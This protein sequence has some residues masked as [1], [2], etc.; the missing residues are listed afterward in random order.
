MFRAFRALVIELGQSRKIVP[1]K[2]N[3]A[4]P[5]KKGS[6]AGST[7]SCQ[8]QWAIL[9]SSD[10]QF[11]SLYICIYF[12][13]CDYHFSHSSFFF[14]LIRIIGLITKWLSLMQLIYLT[15][16]RRS[17]LFSAKG[18]WYDVVHVYLL[19]I[20]ELKKGLNPPSLTD[21]VFVSS[22][23]STAVKTGIV[24]GII[25]LAVSTF[26]FWYCMCTQA[27]MFVTCPWTEFKVTWLQEG[28]AVGR[29]FAMFKNYH[30]DGNKEMIAIGSMNV[31]GSFMSSYL[32]TG[33]RFNIAN[34]D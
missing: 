24:T 25:A 10:C 1:Q 23:L 29:S 5:L 14:F 8:S 28:I 13:A 12:N 21:L 16:K 20:G 11:H 15:K 18:Y 30:I 7:S 34:S 17:L 9:D 27:T 3:W 19:Q 33:N 22:Y 26:H 6:E 31:V 32:T 4:L 2:Q